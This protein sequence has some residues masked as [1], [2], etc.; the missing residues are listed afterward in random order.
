L[1]GSYDIEDYNK[2]VYDEGRRTWKLADIPYTLQ[3][4]RCSY[5]DSCNDQTFEP[6]HFTRTNPLRFSGSYIDEKGNLIN[7]DSTIYFEPQDFNRSALGLTTPIEKVYPNQPYPTSLD[8]DSAQADELTDDGYLK[9]FEYQ[10]VID[11][12]LPTVPYYVN[13]TAFDYGSPS[14]GLASLETSKTINPKIAYP[15]PTADA[16]EAQSLKAYVYPNPYRNDIDYAEQ[17]FEGR[18]A[19]YD[20]RIHFANLPAKC[21]ITIYTLDG[22]M[23][24]QIDHDVDPS[25]PMASHDEWDLITRNTQLVVSGIY[26]WTVEDANGET[27]IGKLVIIM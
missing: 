6:T 2:M 8:A 21:T 23:V 1:L 26:Y 9:Y 14:S 27:Q 24:R 19:Q 5:G 3:D 11:N 25:D 4:L 22:D 20:R 7:W 13:V 15:L 10:F 18:D 16:V 12:L 17:G